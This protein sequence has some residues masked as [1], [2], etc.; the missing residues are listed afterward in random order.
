[1]TRTQGFNQA[2]GKWAGSAEVYSGEGRFVGNGTDRRNVQQVGPDRI[3]IDLS[4]VGPF[5]FAG[6]YF[7][8]DRKTERLYQGPVNV[9]YAEPLS[10]TLVDSNSYW[11]A[12]GFSQRFFLMVLPGGQRQVSM[13]QLSRG[14]QLI[15]TVVGEN[16]KVDDA[17]EGIP[18]LVN[19]SAYDFD[20]DPAAGR[21]EIFLHR[22]GTWRGVLSVLDENMN[23][24][25]AMEYA[26][27]ITPNGNRLD[28][29]LTG[30]AFDPA[31][32]SVK[33]TTNGY[34]AWSEPGEVVGSYNLCGGRALSGHFQHLRPSLRVW[35]RE[36]VTH[37]GDQ[38]A[39]VHLWYRGGQRIGAQF[40]ILTFE[41]GA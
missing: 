39:V 24:M 25:P 8:E 9:G 7:I 12:T 36:V 18:G 15:Y 34:Q 27:S 22:R 32:V 13:A 41:P 11:A 6:H 14:D 28:V 1:M 35:R 33:L 40:G 17:F 38:K 19:G 5:K 29:T 26:E 2:T 31:P 23:E 30:A 37:E 16:Y 20:H 10:E 4:F 21:G 3:R